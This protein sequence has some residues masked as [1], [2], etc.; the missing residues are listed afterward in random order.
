MN[1]TRNPKLTNNSKTLRRNMT[2][3]ERRLWFDFLK[4]MSITVN[5][6]KVIGNYIVDFYIAQAKIV[7]E[8]DGAQHYSDKGI[9][10]DK[11][12][13]EYLNNLGITVLRYSNSDVNKH[14]ENVCEDILRYVNNR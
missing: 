13:D 1:K 9:V 3:E 4:E 7:I 5:R 8:L 2:K 11:V 14:F 6:Q 10:N 12:R